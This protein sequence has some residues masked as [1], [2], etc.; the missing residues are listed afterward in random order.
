MAEKIIKGKVI[1]FG[2]HIRPD[3]YKEVQPGDIIVAGKNFGCGSHRE[4][5]TAIMN[6]LGI[7]AI[8]ADSVARLYYRNCIAFGIPIFG[9]KDVSQIFEEGDEIEIVMGPEKVQVSNVASGAKA[10]A[11]PIPETMAQILEAGG[12]YKLLKMRLA[13]GI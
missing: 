3:F 7:S 5:A 9:I 4:S 13:E 12:V 10:S 6:V 2:D 1:K 11:P 8:V